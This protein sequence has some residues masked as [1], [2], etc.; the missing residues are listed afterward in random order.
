MVIVWKLVFVLSRCSPNIWKAVACTLQIKPCSRETHAN[1]ICRD[2]CLEILSQCVDWS[3]LSSEHSPESVCAGLSPGDPDVSCVSLD[4]FL[5]P[6]DGY[7]R[8]DGQ[9]NVTK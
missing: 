4:S 9:V 3:E 1:Q 5:E 7:R 6:A 8:I 2:V